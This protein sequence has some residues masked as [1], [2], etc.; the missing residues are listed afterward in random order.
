MRRAR[1]SRRFA[2]TKLVEGDETILSALSLEQNEKE[3]VEH[4]LLQLEEESGKDR[5]A[6]LR[7]A[8]FHSLK[9]SAPPP[10]YTPG[11]AKS[12]NEA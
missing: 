5:Q 7:T 3:L 8:A 12:M 2:A 1:H 9:S 6:A 4:I 11:S 10:L